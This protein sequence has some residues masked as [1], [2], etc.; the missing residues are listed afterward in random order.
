MFCIIKVEAGLTEEQERGEVEMQP[1][2]HLPSEIHRETVVGR[3]ER[4]AL[5]RT[6]SVLLGPCAHP[7]TRDKPV[8]S[9]AQQREEC[10][11][12]RQGSK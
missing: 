12:S 8:P 7:R 5:T 2:P 6:P 11:V 1:T 4:L 9:S 3:G 10:R